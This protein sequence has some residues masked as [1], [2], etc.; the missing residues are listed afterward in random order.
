MRLRIEYLLFVVVALGAQTWSASCRMS[1]S[2]PQLEHLILGS[3]SIAALCQK[4]FFNHCSRLLDVECGDIMCCS[5]GE[6]MFLTSV[7]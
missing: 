1:M 2:T 3:W 7:S 4:C 5:V 6:A